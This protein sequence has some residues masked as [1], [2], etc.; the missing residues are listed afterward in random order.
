LSS[1]VLAHISSCVLLL[2]T[3][4]VGGIV[5]YVAEGITRGVGSRVGCCVSGSFGSKVDRLHYFIFT[6]SLFSHGL[7]GVLL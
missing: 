6:S 7:K 1:C 5:L 4:G 3:S 2:A